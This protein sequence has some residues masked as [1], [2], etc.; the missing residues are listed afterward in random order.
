MEVADD[1]ELDRRFVPLS[2]VSEDE[3]LHPDWL[4]RYEWSKAGMTWDDLLMHRRVVVL[5]E[6]GAG[7]TTEFRRQHARI[8]RHNVSFLATIRQ[9]SEKSMARRTNGEP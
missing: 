8:S 9:L 6:A 2:D 1:I 3:S 4:V 5:A 7:K